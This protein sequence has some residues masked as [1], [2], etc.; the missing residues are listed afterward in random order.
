[1]E[2]VLRDRA[3][4]DD[5]TLAH[6]IE[7]GTEAIVLDLQRDL[8]LTISKQRRTTMATFLVTTF[9]DENDGGSGGTGLSLRVEALNNANNFTF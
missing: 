3:V 6:S 8:I 4:T 9:N 5:P 1:L 7:P 2:F